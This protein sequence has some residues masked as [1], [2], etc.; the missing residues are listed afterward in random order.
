MGRGTSSTQSEENNKII[1]HLHHLIRS[2]GLSNYLLR[3]DFIA[4]LFLM[5]RFEE[6]LNSQKD[7]YIGKIFYDDY[8]KFRFSRFIEIGDSEE[9]QN[10]INNQAIPFYRKLT[11]IVHY[12]SKK[13]PS[14]YE[15]NFYKYT[16]IFFREASI[17]KLKSGRLFEI[18]SYVA[19]IERENILSDDFLGDIIESAFEHQGGA[20]RKELGLHRTPR[21]IRELMVELV[22][23]K[24]HHRI[25]DPACGTAGF[26]I[27]AKN[28]IQ[29][30]TS[31]SK[32]PMAEYQKFYFEGLGGCEQ[33]IFIHRF[34]MVV[35]LT[36]G[37]NPLAIKEGDSLGIF[38]YSR[39]RESYDMIITNPP[40]GGKKNQDHYTNLWT[41]NPS[42]TTVLF[43]KLMYEL[44]KIDGMCATVVSEGM[45][46]WDD[47]PSIEMRRILVEDCNL[48]AVISLPQGVFQS[49]KAGLGP[50]TSI[51]VFKKGDKTEKIWFYQITNDGFSNGV[52]RKLIEG[53]QIPDLLDKWKKGKVEAENSFLIPKSKVIESGIYN[54]S[55]GNYVS[56]ISPYTIENYIS[57]SKGLQKKYENNTDILKFLKLIQRT[58]WRLKDNVELVD[59]EARNLLK[60]G[61]AQE[62]K[63]LI[64]SILQRG[65]EY[66]LANLGKLIKEKKQRIRKN[67]YK[68]DIDIVDKISFSD[69]KIHLRKSRETGMDLCIAELNDLIVSKINFHQGAVA[70][71]S[72]GR[73]CCSTHYSVYDI[74]EDEIDP[75]YLLLVLRSPVFL[76]K[77]C[78]AKS[79]G[80]KNESGSEFISEFEFPLPPRE[81][82]QEIVSTVKK[83]KL[84]IDSAKNIE[85]SF[86]IDFNYDHNE[87][88]VPLGDAV[89][90]TKNGWS[91]NCN[92]GP[93]AVL[94]IG[95]LRNGR[96]D[97]SQVKYTDEYK[98]D[99]EKYY[100]K[101]GD[102]F[103]SRG[104]TKELVALAA[105][106][107]EVPPNVVFPDLLTKVELDKSKILPE[108]AVYLFNSNLGR[109][110][111]GVVPEGASPSMVKVSQE[112]MKK[113]MVP[114]F[115]NIEKQKE[116]VQQI[117]K[118]I[119]ALEGVALLRFDAE[120]RIDRILDKIWSKE[121]GGCQ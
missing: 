19:D 32:L 101:E 51:Y 49:P 70:I 14:P 43:L 118:Q 79:E 65:H 44:L 100:V 23:P 30:K 34:A 57:R 42:E 4:L 116:I 46:T 29:K 121:Q 107:C 68:N 89:V 72:I 112:Y 95:C 41:L 13:K 37:M 115:G 38:D 84:V 76:N 103:Y 35:A 120:Q 104:N 54:L 26:L 87:K 21:H 28:Y 60:R 39:D 113:F 86:F 31:L 66:P 102:F 98:Q 45:N 47:G 106:A 61:P 1:T 8:D 7:D 78:G 85:K 5:R 80:I 69:G 99:V 71:N 11:Q 18:I 48:L 114:Y 3:V 111:F 75:E 53:S 20:E 56:G 97:F 90:D 119:K 64:E 83:E 16:E 27:S 55:I 10:F 15:V 22:D 73:I 94:S 92:G 9:L 93:Q 36:H 117:N 96:I 17:Q 110:Y 91:P 40:F 62:I 88:L 109:R 58:D 82:Q 63:E 24:V 67:E 77:V 108:Y 50:K 33:D 25:Y 6:E 81:L 74:N 12:P 105:I 52:K 2:A 59:K